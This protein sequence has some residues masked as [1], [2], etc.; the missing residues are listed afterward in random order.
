MSKEKGKFGEIVAEKYLARKGLKVL[1][2]NYYSRY[3]EIDIIAS[4]RDCLIFVEV[5]LRKK[6]S[7]CSGR[8]SVSS[9]KRRK[10]VKTALTFLSETNSDLSTRFDVIEIQNT[11]SIK[12]G[13]GSN[14]VHLENAFT[15]NDVYAN[16]A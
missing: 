7:F 8:E 5:K 15:L 13:T 2:R 1:A 3:G 9:S 4:N 12:G 10:I 16:I 14:I 6:R 11:E